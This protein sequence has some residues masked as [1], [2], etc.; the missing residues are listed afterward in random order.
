[1]IKSLKRIDIQVFREN[2]ECI[3]VRTILTV[4]YNN[5]NFFYKNEMFAGCKFLYLSKNKTQLRVV[6]LVEKRCM[7]A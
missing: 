3:L 2:K 7:F 1:M 6:I 5:A 4:S